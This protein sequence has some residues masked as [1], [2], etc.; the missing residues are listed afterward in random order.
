MAKTNEPDKL[1]QD[2]AA[3]LAAGMSYGKWKA[4]QPV[5][6][7]KK[8]LPAIGIPT[9]RCACCGV[10]FRA[11]DSPNKIYCG[12][13]CRNKAAYWRSKERGKA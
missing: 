10:E 13:N 2:A 7:V 1:A 5:V 9:R 8:N 4:T 3:A 11:D 12:V 6:A